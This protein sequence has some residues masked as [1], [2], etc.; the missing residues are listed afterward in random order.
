MVLKRLLEKVEL[1]GLATET[2]ECTYIY[3]RNMPKKLPN[4]KKALLSMCISNSIS[5]FNFEK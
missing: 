1:I 5:D 2:S 3:G 4:G